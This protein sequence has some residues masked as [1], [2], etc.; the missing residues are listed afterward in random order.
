MRTA[1][2]CSTA[3]LAHCAAFDVAAMRVSRKSRMSGATTVRASTTAP[4]EVAQGTAATSMGSSEVRARTRSAEWST[5]AARVRTRRGR[6][7]WAGET[8]T[9]SGALF[10][11]PRAAAPRY[12]GRGP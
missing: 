12:R 6:R 2:V 5:D 10:V 9:V 3:S 8:G 11:R 1:Y 7:R 4:G